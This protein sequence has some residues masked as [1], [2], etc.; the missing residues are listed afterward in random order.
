MP[1]KSNVARKFA[2]KERFSVPNFVLLKKNSDKK[3]G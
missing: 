1:K 3:T 2:E